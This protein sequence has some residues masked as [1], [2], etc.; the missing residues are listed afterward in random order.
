MLGRWDKRLVDEASDVPSIIFF[1]ICYRLRALKTL[2]FYLCKIIKHKKK[3]GTI[4][5]KNFARNH[6]KKIILGTSDA[7][8]MSRSSQRPS[9]RAY[10]IEYFQIYSIVC[11]AGENMR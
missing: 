6:E 7:W 11:H 1:I 10:Y 5:A 4:F 8:L 9:D 2:Y 3:N